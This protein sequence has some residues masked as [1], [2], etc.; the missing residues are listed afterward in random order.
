MTLVTE[1]SGTNT[2]GSTGRREKIPEGTLCVVCSDTASGIHYSVASCNGCKTFFRRAI[3]NRQQFKC[4]HDN[5][6]IVD[7]SVRCGC[8][9]CRLNKCFQ[10]GMDPNAIQHD[11]DKIR[12]TK[13]ITK[14]KAANEEILNGNKTS[15]I[16]SRL[17][18]EDS[19]YSPN[20]VS[21]VETSDPNSAIA[22]IINELLA[23]EQKIDYL[24]LSAMEPHSSAFFSMSEPRLLEDD[25]W[26]SKHSAPI[27]ICS[28]L[29]PC[30]P[31]NKHYWILRDLTLM[32]EW[33]K[34]QPVVQNLLLSD[35]MAIVKT[36]APIYP[37]LQLAFYSRND[38][39]DCL[40]YP[41]GTCLERESDDGSFD[42][43]SQPINSM[44]L[45]GIHQRITPKNT[46][47]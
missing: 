28:T 39:P 6:C 23:L 21:S 8:R 10:M 4:Q 38:V 27:H 24:R 31:E 9:S 15:P 2:T 47:A 19:P 46:A 12:Y 44:L 16:D 29:R 34:C 25:A 32:I 26:L 17:S 35:K 43:N 41:D 20:G 40:V 42:K 14:L 7:K 22:N 1:S 30:M 18:N 45:D 36:F 13:R 33:V 11:R 3:V 5:N 37:L